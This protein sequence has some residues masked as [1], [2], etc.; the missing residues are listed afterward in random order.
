M[1]T[2]VAAMIGSAAG[3]VLVGVPALFSAYWVRQS[4]KEQLTAQ[5]EQVRLQIKAQALEQ[6]REPRSRHYADFVYGIEVLLDYLHDHWLGSRL[7][8]D[9]DEMESVLAEVRRQE[10]E[11]HGLWSRVAIEGTSAVAN[12]GIEALNAVGQV[13]TCLSQDL[14]GRRAD[15]QEDVTS[16][17]ERRQ[18]WEAV[19]DCQDTFIVTAR[20]GLQ[21]D[22]TRRISLAVRVDE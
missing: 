5:V 8:S 3:G 19:T 10:R 2:A 18:L 9:A 14:T 22:G 12:A 13:S 16:R 6:R 20:R 11:L 17:R 4:Q 7:G 15:P 1:N 21:D